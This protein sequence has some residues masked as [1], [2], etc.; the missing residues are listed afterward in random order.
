VSSFKGPRYA[1]PTVNGHMDPEVIRRI[2]R[3]NDGRYRACYQEGLRTN[4]ALTGRVTVKFVIDR[5]GAVAIAA[6]GGSDIPD[7]RVRRCVVS[8]F[9]SLSFS[10]PQNGAVTVVYPIVF[11]PE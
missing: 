1:D 2:V 8:S 4:P 9:L 5:S 3:M 7:E 11:S 6:D 10:A